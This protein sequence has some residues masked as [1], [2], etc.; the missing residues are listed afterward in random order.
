[1]QNNMHLM[2]CP[3]IKCCKYGKLRLVLYRLGEGGGGGLGEG[4]GGSGIEIMSL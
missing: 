1:M 3:V 2:V 4:G